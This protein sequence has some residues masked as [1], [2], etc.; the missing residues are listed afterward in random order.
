[1]INAVDTDDVLAALDRIP[2]LFHDTYVYLYLRVF[3]LNRCQDRNGKRRKKRKHTK[4][5]NQTDQ[6]NG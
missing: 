2:F 3:R 6:I 4:T 5:I 1:M